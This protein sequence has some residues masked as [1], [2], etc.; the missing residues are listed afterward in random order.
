MTRQDFVDRII[1]GAANNKDALIHLF[2]ARGFLIDQENGFY[3][4]TYDSQNDDF[5]D[6]NRIL[7]EQNAGY[8][9][10]TEKRS[11]FTRKNYPIGI[12]HLTNVSDIS[13]CEKWFLEPVRESHSVTFPRG[14]INDALRYRN[15]TFGAKVQ[16]M[17]LEPFVARYVKTI[18][19]CNVS[20]IY[21]CDGNHAGPK[22][23]LVD[24]LDS[25]S[26]TWHSIICQ[27]MFHQYQL[28]KWNSDYSVIRFNKSNQF[29]IYYELN[30]AAEMLYPYQFEL[31]MIRKNIMKTFSAKFLREH[32]REEIQQ[33]FSDLAVEQLDDFIKK[34]VHIY[35][36]F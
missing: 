9:K 30:R 8:I 23:V 18:S 29:E 2:K 5:R 26:K 7:K 31:A 20:T 16:V 27:K 32:S 35:G 28:L 25:I 1:E 4:L 10:M 24:T 22:R 36:S 21:S 19:A 6:L 11:P 15:N 34:E 13:W 17:K 12:I 14:V 33:A 3:H